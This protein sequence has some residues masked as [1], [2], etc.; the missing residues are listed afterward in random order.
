[1]MKRWKTPLVAAFLLSLGFAGGSELHAQLTSRVV[2]QPGDAV[3]IRIWP[4][5]NG[6]T[7]EYIIGSSGLLALP[8]VGEI[9]AAGVPVSELEANIRR[10]F[11]TQ[12]RGLAISI[13]PQFSVAV[14]GMVGRPSVYPV[15]PTQ[16]LYEVIAMA[17]GFAGEADLEKVRIVRDGQVIPVNAL[18][19][20]ERGVDINRYQLQSGDQIVVPARGGISVRTI[21]EIVRTVSTLVL[22]YDRLANT[23]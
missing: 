1:M 3:S 8:F 7:G 23:N 16:N 12:Q 18:M 6:Y 15:T 13:I 11:E 19:T 5:D 21:F 4:D 10:S 2:L 9:Q 17:G 22:V 14:T 20:L